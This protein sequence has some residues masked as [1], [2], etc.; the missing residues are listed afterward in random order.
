VRLTNSNNGN[1]YYARTLNWNSTSVMTGNRLV[2]TDVVLPTGLPTADYAFV[3][4]A[5][6]IISDPITFPT[7]TSLPIITGQPKSQTVPAGSNVTFTA[8][9]AGSALSYFW[10]R[11]GSFISGATNTSYTTNNVQVAD[12]GAVFTCIVS[13]FNGPTLSSNAVLTVNPDLPVITAQ[14][15]NM[16][17]AAGSN[18]TFTVVATSVAP[19]S[20]FWRRNG[21]FV[22]GATDS[23]YTT[24]NVQVADSGAMFS[25]LVSNSTG[26]TLSSNAVLTVVATPNDFCSGAFVI[27]NYPYTNSQS[28]VLATS[29]G[30][31]NPQCTMYGFGRGVWYQ[32]TPPNDGEMVVDTF[33]SLFKPVFATY[34]GGCGSLTQ[35]GC[36]DAVVGAARLGEQLGYGGSDVLYYG[37]KLYERAVSLYERHPGS[38]SRVLSCARRPKHYCA[39]AQFQ[40][41]PLL[42]P[43]RQRPNLRRGIQASAYERKLDSPTNKYR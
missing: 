39:G 24:N 32:F 27:A 20:Y 41:L 23:S 43:D 7:A 3:V 4:V 11:D 40:P 2:G 12:S 18:A 16:T 36:N 22:A 30:D 9:A 8:P 25:C 42:L 14:P 13:N 29:E 37:R 1:V 19:R 6:G 15:T 33:G 38:S 34:S 21:S 28:T 31:P 10:R 17:A 26:T 35:I 5:N